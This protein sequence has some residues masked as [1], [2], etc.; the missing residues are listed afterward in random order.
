[1]NE[2]LNV[3]ILKLFNSY[4]EKKEKEILSESVVKN[5]VD[6]PLSLTSSNTQS[7]SLKN[8]RSHNDSAYVLRDLNHQDESSLSK[9]FETKLIS[10]SVSILPEL[11]L[12]NYPK[13]TEIVEESKQTPY[14]LSAGKGKPGVIRRTYNSFKQSKLAKLCR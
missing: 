11:C 3:L 10:G 4:S 5:E 8:N 12:E 9:S 2:T 13:S 6:I 7:S 1:M 14:A